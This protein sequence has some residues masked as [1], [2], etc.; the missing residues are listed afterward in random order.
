MS[1]QE[2]INL[3]LERTHRYYPV[4]VAVNPVLEKELAVKDS[5]KYRELINVM[6][7]EEL[8]INTFGDFIRILPKGKKIVDSGGYLNY[9]ELQP[10]QNYD[11]SQAVRIKDINDLQTHSVNRYLSK[12]EWWPV[13]RSLV[14]VV[15]SYFALRK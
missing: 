3:L 9:I 14:A 6:V 7:D 12:L 13:L 1:D 10:E 2:I 8:V 11:L 5:Y 4:A 15:F